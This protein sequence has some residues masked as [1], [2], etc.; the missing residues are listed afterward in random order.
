MDALN[1]GQAGVPVTP[2]HRSL[3]RWRINGTAR[4]RQTGNAP[5]TNLHGEHQLLLVIFRLVYPKALA[6]EIRTFIL[7]F[8]VNPKLYSRQDISK[9]EKELGLTRKKGST[10]AFQAFTP[11]N[12][13]R[14]Q[15]FWHM[16][17]PIG[18]RGTPRAQ[19]IDIDECGMWLEKK[20]RA[21]GKALHNVRVR[22]PGVY[23]HGEKWT[24]IMG[25]DCADRV[26]VRLA[27]ASGTT[28][29]IFN[30]FVLNTILADPAVAASAPRTLMWDNLSAHKSAVVFNT[31]TFA[32]HRV[33]LRPPYH[34]VD[35]P[36]GYVFNQL[37][38]Q[39]TLRAGEITD[40]LSFSNLVQNIIANLQGFDATFVHCGYA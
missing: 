24:L 33:L 25:I 34:P 28:T 20:Q 21:F 16:A 37:Q 39:L 1:A 23:G 32:G 36:I 26:W 3:D 27:K 13:A 5:A 38:N 14:R 8:S 19:L 40:D 18:V 17:Y 4:L 15:N 9:R 2:S 6:D 30:N 11:I 7:N 22:A 10:T 35:G 29:A 31:V 12:L